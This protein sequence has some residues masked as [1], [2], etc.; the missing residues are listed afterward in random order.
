MLY[1]VIAANTS[2]QMLQYSEVK[3]CVPFNGV[4]RKHLILGHSGN[5]GEL[6][7]SGFANYAINQGWWRCPVTSIEQARFGLWPELAFV[8]RTQK[9]HRLDV[10]NIGD[11][12][13]RGGTGQTRMSVVKSDLLCQMKHC[14]KWKFIMKWKFY[15]VLIK[16][17][18]V[19]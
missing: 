7:E 3:M 5:Q 13:F 8:K 6:L 17:K 2:F 9:Y 14:N 15:N 18:F 12:L 11:L 10:F 16:F 4:L 19:E 1:D